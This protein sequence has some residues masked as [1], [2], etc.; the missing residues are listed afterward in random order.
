MNVVCLVGR[1]TRDPEIRTTQ[2]G[3]SVLNFSVAVDRPFKN[4]STGEYDADFPSCVAFDKT[5]EFIEKYFRKGQR[6][7]LTGRLQTGSYD[8]K[9]GHKVYTTDI[10]VDR[11]EFVESKRS[12]LDY[13]QT[14]AEPDYYDQSDDTDLPFDIT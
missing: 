14:A 10:V 9:D 11:A 3:T 1:L 6:I 7:G 12:E 5:A 13:A 4:K 8:H 2:S